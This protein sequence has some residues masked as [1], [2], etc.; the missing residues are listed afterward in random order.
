MP[1]SPEDPILN[2][3]F[4]PPSRHW[5][6]DESGAFTSTIR[7]GPRRSEYLVLIAQP[8]RV[9]QESLPFAEEATE[10]ALI[11][12]IRGHLECWRSLPVGQAGVTHETA[13]LLDHWRSGETKPTIRVSFAS[14]PRWR[15]VPGRPP[16]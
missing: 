5:A 11:N 3:P 15:R 1:A 6:L 10:N 12:E 2:S 16:C 4:S 8:R 14:L 7:E 13:R 9:R